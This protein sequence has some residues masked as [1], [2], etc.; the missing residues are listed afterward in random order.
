[1]VHTIIFDTLAF[2]KKLEAAGVES[3]Q[4]AAH[5]EAVAEVFD[6]KAPTKYDITQLSQNIEK[7]RHE[8]KLNMEKIRLE[9]EK[10]KSELVKW[11]FGALFIQAAFIISVLKFFH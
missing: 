7:M 1:M 3:K 2:A 8:H 4:T 9:L 5:A 10:I 11:V 6:D